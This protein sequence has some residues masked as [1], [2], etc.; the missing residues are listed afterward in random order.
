MKRSVVIKTLLVQPVR[1]LAV[2]ILNVCEVKY[3][4]HMSDLFLENREKETF[5]YVSIFK[6][7]TLNLTDYNYKL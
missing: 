3:E 7:P 6:L 4:I 1:F 2:K 5:S